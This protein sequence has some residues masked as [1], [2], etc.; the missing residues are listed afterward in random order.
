MKPAL[1]ESANSD[2][3]DT[4]AVRLDLVFAALSD[5]ARRAILEKLDGSDLAARWKALQRS[6]KPAPPATETPTRG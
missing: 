6:D 1:I 3:A 4:A 5:P 2:E